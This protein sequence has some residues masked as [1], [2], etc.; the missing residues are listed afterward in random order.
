MMEFAEEKI[1]KFTWNYVFNPES[2]KK[3][4]DSSRMHQFE[5]VG[6]SPPSKHTPQTLNPQTWQMLLKLKLKKHA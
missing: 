4:T 5:V 3:R 1:V 6:G 2:T